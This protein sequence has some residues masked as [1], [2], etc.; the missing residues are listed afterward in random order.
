MYITAWV[1]KYTRTHTH[2]QLSCIWPS[3]SLCTHRASFGGGFCWG[4]LLA[5]MC[6]CVHVKCTNGCWVCA[7]LKMVYDRVL[8]RT[9]QMCVNAEWQIVRTQN[10]S[11]HA[12]QRIA[13]P[14]TK[15]SACSIYARPAD[16]KYI[17]GW[18]KG[19]W[20]LSRLWQSGVGERAEIR[21]RCVCVCGCGAAFRNGRM[22]NAVVQ[23][24][25]DGM[26]TAATGAHTHTHR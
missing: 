23:L 5:L 16:E 14:S 8:H 7:Y 10:H 17:S 1:V 19:R 3:P 11:H 21:V 26:R 4:W 18:L 2:T 25:D 9:M 22:F 15:Q 20:W 6:V 12:S 13:P 24:H